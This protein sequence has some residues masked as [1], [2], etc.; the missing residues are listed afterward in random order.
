MDLKTKKKY[1]NLC[2]PNED[3]EPDD[4]RNVDLDCFGEEGGGRPVRG[5]K[6]VDRLLNE[7]IFSDRPIYKLFTGHRGSGK[8]TE[9]KRLK[10]QLYNKFNLFPV[11]IDSREIIDLEDR[12]EVPDISDKIEKN[13][14]E[15]KIQYASLQQPEQIVQV[16]RDEYCSKKY[17]EVAEILK[18]ANI[19]VVF[20]YKGN[21]VPCWKIRQQK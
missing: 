12:I 2:D 4:E 8:T 7:I 19:I 3:L 20:Q 18:D 11:Y 14:P 15:Q 5:I 1:Y 13:A 6:W 21:P 17:S 9:F 10:T 16:I